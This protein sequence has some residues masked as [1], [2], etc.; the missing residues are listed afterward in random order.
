M[1]GPA[2]GFGPKCRFGGGLW[3]KVQVLEGALAQIAGFGPKRRFWA[4]AQSAGFGG[5]LWPKVQ[6]LEGALAQIAGLGFGP[7]R[8]FS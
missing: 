2:G 3:P 1:A 6:V 7:K 5:G 8:R 4:L